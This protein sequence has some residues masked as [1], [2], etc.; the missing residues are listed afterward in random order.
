LKGLGIA[1]SSLPGPRDDRKTWPWLKRVFTGTFL[2][3]ERAEWEKIF[4]GT[5]ACCTPVLTNPELEA[6]GF[7]Q[8]PIVTLKETPGLALHEGP[9]GRGPI[10]GQGKG[11]EGGGW[12][13]GGLTPGEGGEEVIAQW[14]G[15][16][17]G[18]DYVEVKGG[19]E[20]ADGKAKL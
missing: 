1:P 18:K 15:W 10:T 4:D 14:V 17:R 2:T 19:L 5:D 7:E 3:K 9:E 12:S 20:V 11:V 8:R 13:S 6:G 16:R